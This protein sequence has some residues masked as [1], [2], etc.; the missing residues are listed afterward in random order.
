VDAVAEAFEPLY[1]LPSWR[2]ER[3]VGSFLVLDFGTPRVRIDDVRDVHAYIGTDFMPVARRIADVLG[4]WH[5]W[6]YWCA[7][8]LSWR[9][10]EIATSESTELEIDRAL[11]VLR[12][13]SLTVVTAGADDGRS[14]FA[15]DLACILK[16]WPTRPY[17]LAAGD[18]QAEWM[19]FQPS[20]EVLSLYADGQLR[21]SQRDE[22]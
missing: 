21:T 22:P 10:R 1:G 15:F 13:Q 6:I 18:D 3:G 17:D 14:S 8:S 11:S 16:T 12:G 4:E 7:W 20:G 9:D 2:V 19:L 5:I